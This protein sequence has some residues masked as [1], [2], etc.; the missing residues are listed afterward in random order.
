VLIIKPAPEA[1]GRKISAGALSTP[2]FV[3]R[4]SGG[5]LIQMNWDTADASASSASILAVDDN[6]NN[7]TTLHAVLQ[8][9]GYTVVQARSGEE[10]L[11][12]A[13]EQE[14]AVILVDVQMPGM[15]GYATVEL[16]REHPRVQNT[17]I[18]FLSA[19][20]QDLIDA[21]K[22]YAVGALDYITKPYNPDLLRAK[23][24][25]LVSHYHRGAELKRQAQVIAQKEV[26]AG[27]AKLAAARAEE[28][29]RLKDK[30]IAILG[31][32]LRSPLTA[33]AGTA[34]LMLRASD[35]P[36]SHQ[37]SA[38]RIV[39]ASDRM[40]RMIEDVLDFTR[41]Q[42]GGGIPVDPVPGDLGELCRHAID[43]LKAAR[44]EQEI[45]FEIQGELG[46][47]W[48]RDRMHQLLSNLLRNAADHGVG[49]IRL[50]ARGTE[51]QIELEVHNRGTPIPDAVL[52]G[53]FEPFKKGAESG[54]S[55][56]GLGLGLYIA[57]EIVR[58][59]GGT[60]EVRSSEHA[61]TTFSCV[62]RR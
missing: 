13:M 18:V 31:H 24:S 29:N 26:E 51:H 27:H 5:R 7:L 28:A 8:P 46:G 32:D 38:A 34:R 45:A 43:E 22:G 57:R 49:P 53:I 37:K 48:D 50:D 14:F 40:T 58:S 6:P 17:P 54:K 60:I 62:W 23:V 39:R 9:L 30:Y 10:A 11:R 47:R 36:E 41:G 44:P 56:G 25:S 12:R 59:H 52:P 35:L 55:S 61:G 19:H 20:H 1:L 15:D 42:L 16:L 21:E 33:I 2:G 4:H 3:L